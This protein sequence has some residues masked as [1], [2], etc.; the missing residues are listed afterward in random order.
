MLKACPFTNH[1]PPLEE[2]RKKNYVKTNKAKKAAIKFT[3]LS[4]AQ[5]PVTRDFLKMAKNQLQLGPV[6]KN[7]LQPRTKF[8]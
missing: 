2:A 4:K 1:Q 8:E 7:S 6:T 5:I 3:I